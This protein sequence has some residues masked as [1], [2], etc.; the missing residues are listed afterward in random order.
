MPAKL[1]DGADPAA[2]V[3]KADQALAEQLQAHRGAVVFGEFRGQQ[4]RQPVAAKQLAHGGARIGPGDQ[5]VL[6]LGQH[7]LDLPN[8]P[9]ALDGPFRMEERC[10]P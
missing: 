3:A 5:I 2:A 8:V 4:G 7:G 1:V 6:F 10:S 9:L